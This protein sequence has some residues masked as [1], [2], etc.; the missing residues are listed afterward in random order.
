[1]VFPTLEY[2]NKFSI[3]RIYSSVQ[4]D[5]KYVFFSWKFFLPDE[6]TSLCKL[7]KMVMNITSNLHV[8]SLGGV[9][10]NYKQAG[11]ELG[12]AQIQ[13]ELGLTLIKI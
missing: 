13:L 9:I 2:L 6:Y 11:A 3:R 8:S 1:M 7:T 4:V 12:Q 5:E 10:R